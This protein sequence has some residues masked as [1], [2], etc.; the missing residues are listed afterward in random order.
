MSLEKPKQPII[1]KEGSSMYVS[2][3][4]YQHI[5]KPYLCETVKYVMCA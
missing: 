3:G 5:K 1:L 2:C 4:I